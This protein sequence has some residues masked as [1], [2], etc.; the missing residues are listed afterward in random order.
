MAQQ[1]AMQQAVIQ[2][3]FAARQAAQAVAEQGS[4]HV[5][6]E[7]QAQGQV[8]VPGGAAVTQDVLVSRP[9]DESQV[10]E[11]VNIEDLWKAFETTSQSW[12]LIMEMQAKVLTVE[13]SIS[14]YKEQGVTIAKL[15]LY[16]SQ[17]LDGLSEQ[18]P[19][20]LNQ[21]FDKLVQFMAIMEYDFD[22]GTDRDQLGR[23]LLGDQAWMANRHRLGLQ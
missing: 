16:Y 18:N 8:H 5:H 1:Q 14:R 17:M 9:V 15:P 19:S 23:K 13:R 11:I 7:I 10:K 20:M 12:P 22:N 2:K 4:M 6:D 21:P 3:E